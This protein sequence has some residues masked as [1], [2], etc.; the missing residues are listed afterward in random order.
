MGVQRRPDNRWIALTP[1]GQGAAYY[2]IGMFKSEKFAAL[3]HDVFA[4]KEG[5][6][7]NFRAE[8]IS[9]AEMEVLKIN[10]LAGLTKGKSKF[11][12]VHW[13]K[14]RKRWMARYSLAYTGEKNIKFGGFC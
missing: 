11:R 3:A 9:E 13:Q 12:G 1:Q 10:R 4:R 8:K 5:R 14:N 6:S 2:Y 7:V